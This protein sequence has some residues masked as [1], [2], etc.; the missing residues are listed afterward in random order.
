[1]NAG[2]APRP[3]TG[4]V[5][6]QHH[7]HAE[8]RSGDGRPVDRA[9]PGGR[10]GQP[11][12]APLARDLLGV[13]ACLRRG[14]CGPAARSCPPG[15]P[16]C[17]RVRLL[18]GLGHDERRS[19]TPLQ[20]PPDFFEHVPL[21]GEARA[22]ARRPGSPRTR[23]AAPARPAPPRPPRRARAHLRPPSRAA[24]RPG[25]RGRWWTP[26]RARASSRYRPMRA[27][28]RQPAAGLA[29]RR[30]RS[31]GPAPRRRVPGRR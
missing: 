14:R 30:R 8:H 16:R 24:A 29:D 6:Q 28:A 1:M 5:E 7:Q 17:L 15:V 2:E 22:A 26:G 20:R 9:P 27:H 21:G 11:L 4:A 18:L 23:R 19:E 12:L 10:L 13:L 25:G 31:T 3:A